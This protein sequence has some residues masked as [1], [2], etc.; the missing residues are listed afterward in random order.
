MAELTEMT[1]RERWDLFYRESPLRQ[2]ALRWFPFPEDAAVLEVGCGYGAMT[3]LLCEK[4]AHVDAVDRDP[5]CVEVVK[6]RFSD[7]DNLHTVCSDIMEYESAQEYDLI[8]MIE[9]LECFDGDEQ[10]LIAH[11]RTMLADDGLLLIGFRNRYGIKYLCGACDE[12]VHRPGESCVVVSKLHSKDQV[13]SMAEKA[14]LTGYHWYYPLPDIGFTQFV[15][16][17]QW[18]PSDSLRDR[19]ICYDPFGEDNTCAQREFN[20]YDDLI[21]NGLLGEMANTVLLVASSKQKELGVDGAVL[22]C[23]REPEHAFVTT[24]RCDGI[25]IKEACFPEGEAAL[26]QLA[27]NLNDLA[28]RGLHTVPAKLEYIYDRKKGCERSRLIMPYMQTEPLLQYIRRLLEHDPQK[29]IEVFDS[30]Y[31]DILASSPHSNDDDPILQRGY[32]DMIPYNAFWQD[33]DLI[34]F[35]QEFCIQ[36]CPARYI[37][38]RALRYTWFHI[39]E[40]EQ[41]LP[42]EEIKQH[43]GL[44]DSWEEY[45]CREDAFTDM[46]RDRAANALIYKWAWEQKPYNVGLLMGVFDLFHTGH[47]NLIRR[48]KARCRYLRVG[49]LSDRLAYKYKGKKPVV[50]QGDRMEVL[51]AVGL[52]DEVVL[53]DGDYVSKVEEWYRR[54]FDCF[55]SGDD[56]AGNSFWEDERKTLRKLGAE[57]EFFPYTQ[58]I[59]STFIREKM[60]GDNE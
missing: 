53:I 18:M 44:S 30:L 34:Y 22:S 38:H 57:I 2:A 39:P 51:R 28:R 7:V 5:E 20:S 41:V 8:V 16:S 60:R 52:I 12:Y 43:F 13:R 36:N 49:V 40:L 27:D 45:A 46:N 31:D 9:F 17:E 59:S 54:P 24:I 19:I 14:G 15:C 6:H 1:I 58:Y 35:D 50:S 33:G 37:M 3:G 29:I 48:A 26:K 10:E 56:Y 32:P 4:A 42:L 21:R 11:L 55:F 47:V 23:D 25:V